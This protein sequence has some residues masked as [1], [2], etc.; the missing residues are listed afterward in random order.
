M[1]DGQPGLFR[2][3]SGSVG[4]T[5]ISATVQEVKATFTE[6]FTS[7]QPDGQPGLFR[8]KSGSVGLTPISATVQE[9]KATF[10]EQFTSMQ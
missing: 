8:V 2:V 9:V 6:Q 5:P 10:T 4:L 3:K 7:M 1:P